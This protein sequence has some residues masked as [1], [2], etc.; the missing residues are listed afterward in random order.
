MAVN[1]FS[2]VSPGVMMPEVMTLCRESSFYI[3]LKWSFTYVHTTRYQSSSLVY[4]S[5]F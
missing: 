4:G 1:P 2:G 5:I 3:I